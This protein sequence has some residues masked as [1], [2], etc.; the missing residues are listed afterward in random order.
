MN[1]YTDS[2]AAGTAVDAGAVNSL[3]LPASWACMGVHGLAWSRV[4][5]AADVYVHWMFMSVASRARRHSI[6]G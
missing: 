4:V 1:L 6:R 3:I 5:S 2:L